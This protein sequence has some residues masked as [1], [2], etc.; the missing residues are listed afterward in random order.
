MATEHSVFAASGEDAITRTLDIHVD[1]TTDGL[2]ASEFENFY[3][4]SRTTEEIVKGDYKR[5]RVLHRMQ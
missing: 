1:H 2:S 5:V 4:I 3:E